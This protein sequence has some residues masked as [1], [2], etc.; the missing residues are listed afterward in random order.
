MT[1]ARPAAV[2]VLA[3]GEGTRMKSATAKV[4]HE[5]GGRSMLGHVVAAARALQPEHLVVVVGHGRDQVTAAL[6]ELDPQATTV[7]QAEQNGTGH[8]V[9]IALD[10]LDHVEGTV[11]VVPGD[12]PLLTPATLVALV[13][14]HE[15]AGAATTLLTAR[16][17]DPTGYGRVVR[18]GP[19]VLRVVEHKDADDA[20]LRIDEIATGHYAFAA[21]P[22]R[23]ALGKLSTDNAQGEE[24]LPD[25]VRLHKDAGLTVGGRVVE[26]WGE[27]VGVNDRI[28]LAVAARV[29]RDR[30]NRAHMLAGVAILDPE[31]TWIDVDVVIEPDATVLPNTQLKGTTVVRRGAVVGPDSTLTSTEVGEGATVRRTTADGAVIGAEATVGPYSYL[32]PGTRLGRGAKV[33]AYVEVKASEIGDGSKV[34]HLAYVGDATIGERSNIGAGTIVVNYDGRAKHK[35]KIG[36]DVRVGSNNS[37]VAPVTIGDGGYTAAGSA[38]TNDVP[39]G[40]LGVGR[41]RQ[42]NIEGWVERK[43][44]KQ[45]T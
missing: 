12:A 31:T 41:A 33:G 22:L 3:A 21:G 30:V 11:V 9:R 1:D 4:L 6:A 10:G 19:D 38:I 26:H 18:E 16:Y 8:A 36:D 42:R 5:L 43:R 20:V 28:Q 15:A 2:V 24:Y 40:A 7:V 13:A 34:P 17:P 35:T 32:R 37:L 39:P 23:E 44:G 14:Q 45:G 29:L 25:V 27:T